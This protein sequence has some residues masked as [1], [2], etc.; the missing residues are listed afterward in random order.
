MTPSSP[1]MP[2]S[3]KRFGWPRIIV[4]LGA[5]SAAIVL[6][7]LFRNELSLKQL[8][9][10]EHRIRQLTEAHPWQAGGVAFG[11]YVIV[12]ALSLPF[13]TVLTILYGW[14]FGFSRAVLLVSFASTTGAT[15]AFLL[16]RYVLRDIAQSRFVLLLDRFNRALEADGA[17]YLIMLRLMHYVPFFVI[18]AVMGLTNIRTRTFWWATQLGMLP[19]TII[20]VFL[21]SSITSLDRIADEGI[22]SLVTKQLAM[23]LTALGVF[24]VVIALIARW[25]KTRKRES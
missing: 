17:F 23:A 13:A 11:L 1:D 6:Y 7:F 25:L 14:L 10:E 5:V 16:S 2:R 22:S 3:A 20:Y 24:P 21:G 8:A 12:T 18:N 19:A 15:C 4:L 9:D